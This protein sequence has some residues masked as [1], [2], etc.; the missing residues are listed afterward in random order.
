MS[1]IS[2]SNNYVSSTYYVVAKGQ[3][4]T[5]T[6]AVKNNNNTGDIVSPAGDVLT[7]SA[8]AFEVLNN[9]GDMLTV[10]AEELEEG[11][12]KFE[13]LKQEV[14]KI[15]TGS[16][17]L[18][19]L[20]AH[21]NHTDLQAWAI[22]VEF[23]DNRK[24]YTES[25]S[26][27]YQSDLQNAD[28]TFAELLERNGIKLNKNEHIELTI[29][30][31]GNLTVTGNISNEK[32]ERIQNALN[33]N[34]SL[35]QNLLITYANQRYPEGNNE[36]YLENQRL[37]VNI[38]LQREYG[39]S[40]SDFEIIETNDRYNIP[41]KRLNINNGNDA[42][43]KSLH[44]NEAM[45]VEKIFSILYNQKIAPDNTPLPSVTFSYQN[46]VFVE[47]GMN[48]EAGLD[49]FA[50][51]VVQSEEIMYGHVNYSITFD[52]NGMIT[53]ATSALEYSF[54]KLFKKNAL[55]DNRNSFDEK[56]RNTS[57]L[58]FNSQVLQ[59]YVFDKKR[60]AKYETG[61]EANFDTFT[62]GKNDKGN[63]SIAINSAIL[64]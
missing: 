22:D 35:G 54:D 5:T 38:I 53:D 59:Q 49:A 23:I 8:E 45:L 7:I 48:D 9:N 10:S 1:A 6:E 24:A 20:R 39:V 64:F 32:S 58:F 3:C 57:N 16:E 31:D 17:Y 62:V 55:S 30:Y 14:K 44:E 15:I 33:N 25:L 37:L 19:M 11:N 29:D 18:Q 28:K 42:L 12:V 46:G 40:L 52:D 13:G 2:F 21:S 4:V 27:K 41:S 36:P 34:K 47:K 51:R 50:S 43:L 61:L 63:F 56:T 26:S 60:L